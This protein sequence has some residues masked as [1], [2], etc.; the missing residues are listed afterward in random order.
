MLL[1]PN[2]YVPH[3]LL[4]NRP[5]IIAIW[6]VNRCIFIPETYWKRSRNIPESFWIVPESFRKHNGSIPESFW[7]RLSSLRNRTGIV[8]ELVPYQCKFISQLFQNQYRIRSE[9]F[10]K[11]SGIPQK[12]RLE[13]SAAAHAP[14]LFLR[15]PKSSI[16]GKGWGGHSYFRK[17]FP[18]SWS[19]NKWSYIFS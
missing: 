11:C 8:Q 16:S 12:H 3:V 10:Q 13:N 19:M 18:E 9:T 7:N 2:V 15:F 5:G 1:N 17:I 6:F 4:W 14:L